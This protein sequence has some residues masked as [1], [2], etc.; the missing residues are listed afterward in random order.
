MGK[1][2]LKRKW[3]GNASLPELLDRL[4]QSLPMLHG[5]ASSQPDWCDLTHCLGQVRAGLSGRA[6]RRSPASRTRQ[7]A[8]LSL[9]LFS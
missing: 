3:T 1:R 9:P 5:V 4:E 2:V 7:P 8:A 6:V